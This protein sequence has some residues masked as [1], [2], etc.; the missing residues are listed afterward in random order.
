MSEVIEFKPKEKEPEE[1]IRY[2]CFCASCGFGIMKFFKTDID[3]C[4]YDVECGNCGIVFD[5]LK[6][7]DTEG[8]VPDVED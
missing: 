3:S 1:E 5:T 6:G 8:D 4:E 7:I 2:Q